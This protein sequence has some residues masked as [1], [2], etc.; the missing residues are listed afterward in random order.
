MNHK[1]DN[2]VC[3]NCGTIR[4]KKLHRKLVRTYSK[5]INGIWEDIPIHRENFEYEYNNKTFIRP[6][7]VTK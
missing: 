2:D 5:L 4:L 6:D 3:L 7:C 1:W